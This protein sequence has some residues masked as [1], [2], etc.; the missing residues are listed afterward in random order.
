M[1]AGA[2]VVVGLTTLSNSQAG[3]AVGV[4]ERPRIALPATPNALLTVTDDE[5]ELTS[6]VIVTLTPEGQGGSIVTI[7]VNADG[8]AGFGVQRRPLDAF[9]DPA[10]PDGLVMAV[11]DMLSIT[12]ERSLA[13]D[14]AG[15]EAVL[16]PLG[17]VQVVLPEAVIDSDAVAVEPPPE[18]GADDVEPGPQGVIVTAGPQVL[19]T[20]Q[21][22]A[23]LTA[24]DDDV[25]AYD[26]HTIDVAMWTALAQNSPITVPP[27]PV[28]TDDAGWPL[29]PATAEAL[30]VSLFAGEV[31]VRDL[32]A[33][34]PA[35]IGNPTGADVVVLDRA[36]ASM[37]FAQ[38]SPAL[39]LTP[40]IGSNMRLLVQYTDDQ[41]AAGSDVYESNAVLAREVTGRLL[42]LRANIVSVDTEATGAP[43][44]TLVEVADPR[45]LDEMTQG[46]D[47]IF[48]PSEV[49]I[50]TTVVEGVDMIVTLGTAF[51]ER[52]SAAAGDGGAGPG[53]TPSGTVEGDG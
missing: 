48:G 29:P 22:V 21:I 9:F 41:L 24:V 17:P 31:G 15:L 12:I 47:I 7:P 36:D 37:V 13:V 18:E 28:A 50:A 42:F 30:L 8:T 33:V 51:L 49:R 43:E 20:A 32:A 3:E 44:L 34:E 2:L 39:V 52:E 19:D 45:R 11:E 53:S 4:D 1:I 26:Q 46:A 25:P 40:N 27:P 16:A 23:V 10:D 38:I 35:E 14:P 5:G 6:V